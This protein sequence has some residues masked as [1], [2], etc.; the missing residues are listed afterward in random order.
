MIYSKRMQ[1]FRRNF[2]YNRCQ[3]CGCLSSNLIQNDWLDDTDGLIYY[4]SDCSHKWFEIYCTI[5]NWNKQEI[6]RALRKF[7]GISKFVFR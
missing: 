7:M 1:K 2:K 6:K 4:C 5:D 3:R